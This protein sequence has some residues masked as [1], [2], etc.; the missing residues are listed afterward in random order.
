MDKQDIRDEFGGMINMMLNIMYGLLAMALIIAALGVVNTLAM[1]VFERQQEI[2]MLRAIGLDRRQVK[3]MIR[4]EAVVISLF[5]ALVGVAM[6]SFLGWAIGQTL[7]DSIP[8]YAMVMPWDRIGIFLLL[9]ALVGVLAA[10]WS[11][12]SAA[13]LNMLNAIKAE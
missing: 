7:K 1:S 13:K 8:G 12:R 4:L 11:A 6:G 10:M 9:A 3:R 2:G 5:G